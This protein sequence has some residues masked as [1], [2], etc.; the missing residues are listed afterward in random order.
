MKEGPTW[1]RAIGKSG[2]SEILIWI[3]GTEHS[4]GDQETEEGPVY[5]F[6]LYSIE[7]LLAGTSFF[8]ISGDRKTPAWQELK[9]KGWSGKRRL[10]QGPREPSG[11]W[12]AAEHLA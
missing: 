4:R 1:T 2:L 6:L 11:D 10:L 9:S 7:V 5:I 12:K 8:T 3:M